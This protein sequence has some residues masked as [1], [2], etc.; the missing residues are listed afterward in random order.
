MSAGEIEKASKPATLAILDAATGAELYSGTG[1][2][3]FSNTPLSVANGHIYFTT[4]D[5]TLLQF[6]IP[7]ER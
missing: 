5:N 3:S 6:G 7:E 2:T 1:A 4:H